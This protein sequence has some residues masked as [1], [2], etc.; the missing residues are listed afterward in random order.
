MQG[1]ALGA[2]NGIKALTEG[3]GPLSFGLLMGLYE[4]TPTP[5]APYLLASLLALWY[6]SS[7][8]SSLIISRLRLHRAF[9]QTFELPEEPEVLQARGLAK[10]GVESVG[11][12]AAEDEEDGDL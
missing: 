12:L 10:G 4:D 9:L 2:L 8:P 7:S 1:E 3:F 5:G 6:V 11:L